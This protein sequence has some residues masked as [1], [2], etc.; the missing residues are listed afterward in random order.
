MKRF[1][2]LILALHI[3]CF[4]EHT[5]THTH[6]VLAAAGR[7]LKGQESEEGGDQSTHRPGHETDEAEETQAERGRRTESQFYNLDYPN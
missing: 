4:L 2:T 5:H 1:L 3:F 7:G 6:R